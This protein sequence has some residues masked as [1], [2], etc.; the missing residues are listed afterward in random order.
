MMVVFKSLFLFLCFLLTLCMYTTVVSKMWTCMDAAARSSSRRI[1]FFAYF[2]YFVSLFLAIVSHYLQL[3]RDQAT[4]RI[5][6]VYWLNRLYSTSTP[7]H[8]KELLSTLM[9]AWITTQTKKVAQTEM[10]EEAEAGQESQH[11]C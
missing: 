2:I 9:P 4:D 11:Q 10:G 5:Q 6:P 3:R 1:H 8:L 7:Q